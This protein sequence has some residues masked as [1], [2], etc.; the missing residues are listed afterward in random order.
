MG[1][2]AELRTRLSPIGAVVEELRASSEEVGAI[3]VFLGV[4]RGVSRG[5]RVLRLEYEAHPEL[6]PEV[7][8]RL[9]GEVRERHGILDAVIE[10]KVG[11][12]DVGEPVMCVAVASRHRR[13]GFSAL[14]ELVERVKH[15]APIWK[16]EVTEEG[17]YWVE[18]RGGEPFIELVSPVEVSVNEEVSAQELIARLGLR[19]EDVR[20]VREDRE[21]ESKALLRR[22]DRVKIVP[23]RVRPSS[24]SSQ[25]GE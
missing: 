6:A 12:A 1:V 19:A 15:E 9:I 22:G 18:E 10:H 16:K 13:E 5:R 7:L 4:V 14:R 8:R 25:R 2:R 20:I 11:T 23:A 21:V 24:A 17:A 3:L